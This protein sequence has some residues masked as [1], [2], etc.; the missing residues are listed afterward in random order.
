MSPSTSSSRPPLPSP[1]AFSSPPSDPLP[2]SSPPS[3]SPTLQEHSYPGEGTPLKPFVV[4]WT[5][6]IDL[7]NPR[8]RSKLWRWGLTSQ[9]ALQ[10]FIVSYATSGYAGAAPGLNKEFGAGKEL[11]TVGISTFVIGQALGSLLWA[12]LSE[13][14]GRKLVLLPTLAAFSLFAAGVSLAQNIWTI[15]ICRFFMGIFGSSIVSNGPGSMNDIWSPNEIALPLTLMSIAPFL[16]PVLGPI[17]S[18]YISEFGGEQ[19]WRWLNSVIPFM[20]LAIWIVALFLPETYPLTIL[21][22]R[23]THLSKISGMSF[24]S[25]YDHGQPRKSIIQTVSQFVKRPI[26]FLF[27]EPIVFLLSL[28]TAIIF[29]ILYLFFVSY[30]IMYQTERGWTQGKG[31]LP[32]IAIAIGLFVGVPISRFMARFYQ[33]AVAASP[34]GRAAP[35]ERLY[36]AMLGSILL[37]VSLF[38]MA[39]TSNPSIHWLA[40]TSAG[41]FYGC[42]MLGMMGSVMMYLAD[43]YTI[44]SASVFAAN[45]VI[46]YVLGAIFP[47]FGQIMFTKL[48]TP[49]SLTLLGFIALACT[50]LPFVFYKFGPRIRSFSKHVPQAPVPPPSTTVQLESTQQVSPIYLHPGEEGVRVEKMQDGIDLRE[51]LDVEKQ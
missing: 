33:K 9:V 34:T 45:S 1:S 30:P 51:S 43:T 29:G 44:Y 24:V 35:E 18:G 2:S 19:S 6:P 23:A 17:V 12:P 7:S 21:R 36:F 42:G 10:M 11:V 46:R 50:P 16:G 14:F 39:W 32:F 13:I 31:G 27:Q 26:I 47:L 37:P 41:V 49:W 40:P 20:G 38:W 22:N 25:I 48:T 5:E 15:L 3:R 8:A 4:S 28:W